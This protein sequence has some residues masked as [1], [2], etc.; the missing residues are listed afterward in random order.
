MREHDVPQPQNGNRRDNVNQQKAPHNAPLDAHG[1]SG[2]ADEARG[3]R[4]EFSRRE[5]RD[6]RPVEIRNKA[7]LR[8]GELAQGT[9]RP[10][11]MASCP[12]SFATFRL[13]ISTLFGILTKLVF[14]QAFPIRER[15]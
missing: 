3:K 4:P 2:V 9:L 6:D 12:S 7:V 15:N 8:R 1:T 13:Q 11:T 5:S 10:A 14:L